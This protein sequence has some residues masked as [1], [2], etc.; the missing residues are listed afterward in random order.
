MASYGPVTPE[1]M[2]G[3]RILSYSPAPEISVPLFLSQKLGRGFETDT[4]VLLV[5]WGWG[6]RAGLVSTQ[7][8][9]RLLTM[10]IRHTFIWYENFGQVDQVRSYT[11]KE[12]NE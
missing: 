1:S 4:S 2:E 7:A 11:S 10:L 12:R 8:G 5:V 3:A 9:H 6:S